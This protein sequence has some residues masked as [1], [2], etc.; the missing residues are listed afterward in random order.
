M[1]AA[2]LE[3]VF[4][5]GQQPAHTLHMPTYSSAAAMSGAGGWE[6]TLRGQKGAKE[7]AGGG[8]RGREWANEG[9][10]CKTDT[11]QMA[12]GSFLLLLLRV[13]QTRLLCTTLRTC[14]QLCI[15]YVAYQ[16]EM[17]QANEGR[18]SSITCQDSC[19]VSSGV[20]RPGCHNRSIWPGETAAK[21]AAA[22]PSCNTNNSNN[23]AKDS[24]NKTVKLSAL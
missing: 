11:K 6:G 15:T 20:L 10:L 13:Y 9:A 21:V 8:G 4:P 7:A 5:P 14:R 17:M 2:L 16:P 12:T 24:N 18:D 1:A 22:I 3:V 23:N 19:G